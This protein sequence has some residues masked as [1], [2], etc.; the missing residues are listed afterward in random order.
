M[1]VTLCSIECPLCIRQSLSVDTAISMVL[2]D[3]VWDRIR[4]GRD[5]VLSNK[6]TLTGS[7][8]SDEGRFD[9]WPHV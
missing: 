7:S 3:F 5:D 6:I 4:R 1:H 2:T 9:F 8:K